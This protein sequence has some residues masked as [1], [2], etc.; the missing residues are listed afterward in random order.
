MQSRETILVPKH[1]KK[2]SS[3][4]PQWDESKKVHY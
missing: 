4:V 2:G 1:I 3:H